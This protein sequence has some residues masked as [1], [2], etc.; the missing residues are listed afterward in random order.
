MRPSMERRGVSPLIRI[1]RRSPEKRMEKSVEEKK[2]VEAVRDTKNCRGQVWR[3]VN[4]VRSFGLIEDLLGGALE[5]AL[6]P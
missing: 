1:D 4:P 3:Y 6:H 2:E 5:E